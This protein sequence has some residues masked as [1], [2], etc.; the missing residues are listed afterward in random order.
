[1]SLSA[2]QK[3]YADV[4]LE[5]LEDDL[6]MGR[7]KLAGAEFILR[8]MSLKTRN[9]KCDCGCDM[10]PTEK[11][12]KVRQEVQ[13]LEGTIKWIKGLASGDGEA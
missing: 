13:D 2:K 8:T 11:T 3:K 5:S 4:A 7:L 12:D 9:E 1:M 10:T 6:A